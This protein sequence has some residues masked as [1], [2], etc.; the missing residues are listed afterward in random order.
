M[1]NSIIK[2]KAN[3]DIRN[4]EKNKKVLESEIKGKRLH[5]NPSAFS[6]SECR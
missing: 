4:W 2:N 5:K 3:P 1:I 6:Q